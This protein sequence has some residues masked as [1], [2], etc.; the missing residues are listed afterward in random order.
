MHALVAKKEEKIRATDEFSD[1]VTAAI[2]ACSISPRGSPAADVQVLTD[3]LE[4]QMARRSAQDCHRKEAERLHREVRQEEETIAVKKGERRNLLESGH[5][6]TRDEFLKHAEATEVHKEC[7]RRRTE[8]EHRLKA[9][10]ENPAV[11]DAF[12][13]EL[14]QTDIH[15]LADVNATISSRM[16]EIEGKISILQ[17]NH[18]SVA[19]RLHGMENEDEIVL[20]RMNTAALTGDLNDAARQ[21]AKLVIA[22]IMLRKGIEKYE[23]ERQPAVF[24]EAERYFRSVTGGRYI[25]VIQPL[26]SDLI[27]VEDREGK[28]IPATLLSRGTAEQLY[29]S[30][31]FGYITEYGYHDEHLPAVFDDIL[32]NFDPE[33]QQRS[34]EAIA[35]LSDKNQVVFFT[36][37]PDT[38]Q[39]LLDTRP[40]AKLIEL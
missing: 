3:T 4:E 40:D 1:E 34:C 24:K 9:A 22:R 7:M 16:K 12:L 10:A 26:G 32:V 8:A 5:A 2:N 23:K 17:Q 31:R 39:M 27:L 18:G 19:H 38:A 11:Y 13:E 25:R 35:E 29:L 28:R 14:R 36:C 33:R 37:H 30:L 21:W 6:E 20:L 15:E